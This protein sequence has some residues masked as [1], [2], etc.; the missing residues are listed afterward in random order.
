[1][2][3]IP[4]QSVPETPETGPRNACGAA[5]MAICGGH[6]GSGNRGPSLWE[7]TDLPAVAEKPEF[8]GCHVHVKLPRREAVPDGGP[9]DGEHFRLLAVRVIPHLPSPAGGCPPPGVRCEFRRKQPG[10]R[11]GQHPRYKPSVQG[12]GSAGAAIVSEATKGSS[13]K[14]KPAPEFEV[15]T[16]QRS[17]GSGTTCTER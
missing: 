17:A 8:H 5:S 4:K 12:A 14:L 11:N 15:L 7:S 3:W 6:A 2:L 10:N 9:A 1:M 13:E 16:R